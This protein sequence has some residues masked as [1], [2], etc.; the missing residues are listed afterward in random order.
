[1]KKR[2]LFYFTQ[3]IAIFII[4]YFS[5]FLYWRDLDK[6][7]VFFIER[8]WNVILIFFLIALLTNLF[9]IVSYRTLQN[10][11]FE[12]LKDLIAIVGR[13]FFI[14]LIVSFAEFFIFFK[15]KIGRVIYINLY[16]LLVLFYVVESYFIYIVFGKRKKKVLWLSSVPFSSVQ[17][18][19]L[20]NM[21]NIDV[22]E[23]KKT[24]NT[25]DKGDLVVYDYPP[26]DRKKLNG[27]LKVIISTK[28]PVDLITYVEEITEKIP[29]KY[30]DE[31]W[32]L[33]NIRTYENIY[34]KVRR[35]VNLISSILLLMILFPI[36]FLFAAAHCIESWGPVFY[37]Q[38]RVGYEGKTFRMI[39][40]RSMV[41]EAEQNG[42]QFAE[43]HDPRVTKI[44]KLMR[45][46][47]IDEVPQLVNVLKG[48]MNLIGPRP[49]RGDFIEM[50]E[51]QIPYYK[52]RLEVRPGLTGWAQV[53]YPYAG[54]NI[55]EH[56]KKL[57]YDFYYIKN[58]SLALDILILLKTIKTI[59]S[60]RGT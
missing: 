10:R 24:G 41:N 25:K 48:D 3:A 29:L 50:L 47:R 42:P 45:R 19:Y 40:F 7:T 13:L 37:I 2:T 31:L 51:K 38:K 8:L 5:F 56:L 22:I 46:Y 57:E 33:K 55:E 23:T 32:L 16:F 60:R 18:D 11:E 20:S 17:K 34:D 6:A 53:N 12:F 39:K 35:M 49:E 58:R 54:Q 30:V 27:I 52:M 44:G 36:G 43:K 59:I 1:M 4:I 28:N 15:T 26:K 9:D 14:I 21:N